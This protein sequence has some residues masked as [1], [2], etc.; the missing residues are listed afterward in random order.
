MSFNQEDGEQT[1]DY[2][3][4]KFNKIGDRGIMTGIWLEHCQACSVPEIASV[5]NRSG[6]D[7]DIIT[8]Y[9]ESPEFK[10]M[11][12]HLNDGGFVVFRTEL[13]DNIE[14]FSTWWYPKDP[15]HITMFSSKS[16][17]YVASLLGGAVLGCD[18][19]NITVI[20]VG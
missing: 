13:T 7:Y 17:D 1:D 10:K 3:N 18:K 4:K 15:T 19:K 16:M 20:K 11:K 8:G 5:F 14:D 6:I 2:R 12:S 9:L